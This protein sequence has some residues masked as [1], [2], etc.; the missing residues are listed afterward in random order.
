MIDL[1]EDRDRF[2]RLLD[3]LRRAGQKMRRG[4][5]MDGQDRPLAFDIDIRSVEFGRDLLRQRGDIG[6]LFRRLDGA[7]RT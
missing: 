7:V 2:K 4:A 5:G 6:R 3:K 1:A